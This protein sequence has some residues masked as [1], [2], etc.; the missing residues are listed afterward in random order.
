MSEIDEVSR[1]LGVLTSQNEISGQQ[2]ATLVKK[3]DG[4]QA[5]MRDIKEIAR[6]AV[7]RAE[8][9][10]ER[11]DDIEP[12]V[13]DYKKLKQ[14]GIGVLGLIGLGSGAAGAGLREVIGK[15]F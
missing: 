8:R 6:E 9:L 10:E 4:V 13:E 7:A 5:E 14:R 1:L 15:F 2:M 12:N 11:L 3:F